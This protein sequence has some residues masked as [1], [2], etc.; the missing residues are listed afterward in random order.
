MK[1]NLFAAGAFAL[2]L[3]MPL[4]AYAQQAAPSASRAYGNKTVPSEA[5][6]QRHWAKRFG[7]LNLSGDQQQRIQSIIHQYADRKSVV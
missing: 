4:G 7:G 3:A 6:L 5:K 2:A 1:M